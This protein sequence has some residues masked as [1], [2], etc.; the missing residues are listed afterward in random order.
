MT[1]ET[2]RD[3]LI[4]G[5]AIIA[6][7]AILSVLA[8]AC[9]ARA[10]PGALDRSD[11]PTVAPRG[12][13]SADVSGPAASIESTPAQR[14]LALAIAK[15]AVNEASLAH[16]RPADVALIAQVANGHG[17]TDVERLAWLRQH[18]SCVLTDRP[19]RRGEERTNCLWTRTLLDSDEQPAAWPA[20]LEWSGYV[21]R[22][23]DVRRLALLLVL[24][25]AR[26]PYPCIGH[27]T[28]WG[29]RVLDMGI[30][31]RRGLIALDCTTVGNV[32]FVRGAR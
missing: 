1:R 30:A 5:V 14:A 22:W 20:H 28:T 12:A 13:D 17:Y 25:R 26:T 6:G 18:S 24:H 8:R 10:Q 29:S 4:G 32:G 9:E 16:C 11:Q 23:R 7:L 27:P 19:L 15:V 21:T 3:L 2:A 31:T